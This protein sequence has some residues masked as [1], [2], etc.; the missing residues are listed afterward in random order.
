MAEMADLTSLKEGND[1]GGLKSALQQVG[2]ACICIMPIG[3]TTVSKIAS[4][5]FPGSMH[6]LITI[7]ILSK[8]LPNNAE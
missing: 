1:Q 4:G 2:L 5:H 6:K 3:A 7:C 8:L